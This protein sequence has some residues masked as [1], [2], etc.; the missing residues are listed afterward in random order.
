LG[1]GVEMRVSKHAKKR[2]KE[3]CG[4]KVK[5]HDRAAEVAMRDGLHHKDC[6]GRLKKHVDYLFLNHRKGNNIRL[7]GD[8][9]FIF[10]G[11]TLITLLKLPNIYKDAVNKIIGRK[12]D[13]KAQ[14]L[15]VKHDL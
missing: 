3:R 7:Y 8:N 15:G 5:C 6:T 9:V 4:L 2:M 1:K 12:R 13:A 14:E 10:E 11:V